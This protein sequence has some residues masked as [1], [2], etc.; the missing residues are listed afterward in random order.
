[1]TYVI[2]LNFLCNINKLDSGINLRVEHYWRARKTTM[3]NGNEPPRQNGILLRSRSFVLEW[4]VST[5][6]LRSINP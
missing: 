4:A 5:Q 6:C 2:H 3:K 1:M